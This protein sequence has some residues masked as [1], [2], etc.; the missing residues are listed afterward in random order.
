MTLQTTPRNDY[1]FANLSDSQLQKLRET[2]QKLN[3]ET[4]KEII[5]LAYTKD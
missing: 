4:G 5:I 3:V 1:Q 2:E